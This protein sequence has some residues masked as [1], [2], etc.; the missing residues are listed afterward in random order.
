MQCV[1]SGIPGNYPR[2]TPFNGLTEGVSLQQT[3]SGLTPGNIYV[4]EFWTGGGDESLLYLDNGLFSV[5]VG[6]G[7]IFLQN[8]STAPGP[9]TSIGMRYIVQFVAASSSH[10]IRFT[11]WGHICFSCAELVLDDVLLYT[12]GELSSSVSPCV[13]GINAQDES[14]SPLIYPNPNDGRFVIS[15]PGC[16]N[17]ESRVQIVNGMGQ[18]VWE[19]TADLRSDG[20]SVQINMARSLSPG[21]YTARIICSSGQKTERFIISRNEN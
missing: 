14:S 20:K 8:N 4:L 12:Q 21:V 19:Q 2:S 6:F 17:K 15:I 7:K 11:S 16:D 10:T 13:T 5:D 3:V 9:D 1:V 18:I